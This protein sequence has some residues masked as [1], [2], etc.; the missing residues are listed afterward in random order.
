MKLMRQLKTLRV[1]NSQNET[2]LS[3]ICSL[4]SGNSQTRNSLYTMRVYRPSLLNHAIS[5]LTYAL[6]N[7]T[8]QYEN[9]Q[10]R[11]SQQTET[12]KHDK[13]NKLSLMIIIC[14]RFTYSNWIVKGWGNEIGMNFNFSSIHE[15]LV[16]PIHDATKNILLL[17]LLCSLLQLQLQLCNRAYTAYDIAQQTGKLRTPVTVGQQ[18]KSS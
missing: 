5:W 15:V 14:V 9:T 8:K 11:V 1:G 3:S 13:H 18:D 16:L 7:K 2:T 17:Q 12:T 4:W 6:T 10:L